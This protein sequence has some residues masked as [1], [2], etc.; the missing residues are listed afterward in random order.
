MKSL[1]TLLLSISLMHI[2]SVLAEE[3]PK[4]EPFPFVEFIAEPRDASDEEETIYIEEETE[5]SKR[6]DPQHI[7]YMRGQLAYWFEDYEAAYQLWKPLAEDG[8]AKAQATFG[9]LY[10]RGLGVEKNY[11]I[12]F[13]WY[14]KS[15]DQGYIIA[16]HNLGIMYENGLGVEQDY[17][18]AIELYQL[19][20]DKAYGNSVYNLGLMYLNALGVDQDKDKAIHLLKSAHQLKVNEAAGSLADLGIK[21]KVEKPIDHN[22]Q[23]MRHDS[24]KQKP[25]ADW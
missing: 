19:G 23:T 25:P 15:A 5:L 21:V 24:F 13:S 11:N 8:L 7:R 22:P 6:M 9:W 10:H 2:S 14:Q 18:K 1:V 12:A 4:V 17:K 20:A 16:Q 3:L